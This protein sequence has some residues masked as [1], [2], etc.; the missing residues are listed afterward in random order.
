MSR[1]AA[2]CTEADLKRAVKA[3]MAIGTHTVVELLPDGTIRI[4]QKE[5][6]APASRGKDITL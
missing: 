2:R 3:A 6:L 1:R 4:V 5:E